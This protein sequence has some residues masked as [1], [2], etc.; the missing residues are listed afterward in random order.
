MGKEVKNLA[1]CVDTENRADPYNIKG[2]RFFHFENFKPLCCKV[3][4]LAFSG[5][6]FSGHITYDMKFCESEV[7]PMPKNTCCRLEDEHGAVGIYVSQAKSAMGKTRDKFGLRYEK[8]PPTVD[9]ADVTSAQDENGNEFGPDEVRGFLEI[10]LERKRFGGKLE[11][12]GTSGT[13]DY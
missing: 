11:C 13:M 2:P 1:A 3:D 5:N 4:R 9:L 10:L 12:G 6:L 8:S 7:R